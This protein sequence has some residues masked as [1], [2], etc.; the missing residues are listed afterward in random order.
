MKLTQVRKKQMKGLPVGS[1]QL[2]SC[3]VEF[4]EDELDN[5]LDNT[6][7]ATPGGVEDL[8]SF[9]LSKFSRDVATKVY[10]SSSPAPAA[11]S[12]ALAGY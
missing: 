9:V 10:S 8:T 5:L 7:V 11:L 1:Q 12:K 4:T 2:Y 3:T 6:V